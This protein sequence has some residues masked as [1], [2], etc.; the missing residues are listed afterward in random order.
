MAEFPGFTIWTDA[1]LADTHDLTT[2]EHG[3]YLLMLMKMWRAGG[4]LP[5][6]EA[7]LARIAGVGRREWDRIRDH[8]MPFFRL[9]NGQITQGRLQDELRRARSRSQKAAESARAKYRKN[10]DVGSA[11]AGAKQCLDD[12]SITIAIDKEKKVPADPSKRGTRLPA[13]FQPDIGEAMR[14]GLPEQRAKSEAAK[15]VDYW[16][17]KSGAGATKKDWPATWRVWVRT[18]LDRMG[19]GGRAPPEENDYWR[20]QRELTEEAERRAGYGKRSDGENQ[21]PTFDLGPRDYEVGK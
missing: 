6:D 12:A 2:L 9:E 5:N 8:I 16:R 18:A 7:K 19:G 10:N 13:D 14:L 15:F 17:S 1:Y 3:A 11:N 4:Y 20:R 21:Q